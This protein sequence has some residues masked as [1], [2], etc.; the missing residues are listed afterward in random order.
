MSIRKRNLH[1]GPVTMRDVAELANVSQSTVSRVLSQSNSPIPIGEETQQR[2]LEAVRQLGYQPN[3]HAGSLR[4]Q[5]TQMLAMMIADVANPFYHPI[6]RAVQ[7]IAHQHRYDV[8]V[9]NSDHMRENELLFCDALVRRPVDGVIMSPYHLT[10][11]EIGWLISRTGAKVAV[12][13]SHLNHP[14]IDIVASDDAQITFET[15]RWLIEEKG[16]RRIAIIRPPQGFA[17]GVRRYRA[18]EQAVRQAGLVVHEECVRDGDWSVESGQA[19]MAALLDLPEPPSAVFACSDHMAIGAL[20]AAQDRNVRVPEEIAIVGFDDIP[21]A[22]W[23]RP[24]LTT[25]AQNPAAIGQAL[26]LAVF[27]RIEEGEDLPQ[28]RFD[29]ACELRVRESV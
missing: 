13:G 18:F 26:A 23:V 15:I 29:V 10:D 1:P 11:E 24:R 7:D 19:A 9:A 2:V 21:A 8:L 27:E 22:S 16:H 17:V 12:L 28:R 3:L 20:L 4:G 14:A 25:I 5:K 6:V